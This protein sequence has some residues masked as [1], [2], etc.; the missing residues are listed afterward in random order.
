MDEERE[1]ERRD[2]ARS[3][4]VTAMLL[5]PVPLPASFFLLPSCW[6]DRSASFLI[7]AGAAGREPY[8]I[9]FPSSF[10]EERNKKLSNDFEV[11]ERDDVTWVANPLA[12]EVA[13]QQGEEILDGLHQR[14]GGPSE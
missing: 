12:V 5:L 11:S 6:N 3:F 1:R 13:N 10:F 8:Q 2:N 14:E 4:P 9:E 7:V